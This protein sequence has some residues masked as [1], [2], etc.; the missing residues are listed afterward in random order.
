VCSTYAGMLQT[1]LARSV[2]NCSWS[3]PIVSGSDLEWKYMQTIG[4]LAGYD[5]VLS[6]ENNHR[7]RF[8]YHLRVR[9][10]VILGGSLSMH[11]MAS[12]SY[13]ENDQFA[14]LPRQHSPYYFMGAY[15]MFVRVNLCHLQGNK[16][17]SFFDIVDPVLRDPQDARD[18][19]YAQPATVLSYYRVPFFGRNLDLASNYPDIPTY[20]GQVQDISFITAISRVTHTQDACVQQTSSIDVFGITVPKCVCTRT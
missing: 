7:M 3:D 14:F 16:L 11:Q 10:D 6:H 1:P 5:F 9:T 2:L 8:R 18:I 12:Y 20:R 15:M 4:Y 13:L 19:G 17:C